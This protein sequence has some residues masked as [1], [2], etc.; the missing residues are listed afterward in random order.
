MALHPYEVE[1]LS[2][3]LALLRENGETP[4]AVEVDSV[5]GRVKLVYEFKDDE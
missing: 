2:D 4:G 5:N 3:V 1:R